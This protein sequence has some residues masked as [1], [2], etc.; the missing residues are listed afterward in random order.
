ME[1]NDDIRFLEK[2]FMN[3]ILGSIRDSWPVLFDTFVI[4]PSTEEEDTKL[5]FD[6]IICGIPISVR[7]R[8][9]KYINYRESNGSRTGLTIRSG[10]KCGRTTEIDKLR[11]G[12]GKLYFY[13]WMDQNEESIIGW[14]LIDIDKIRDKLD[15]FGKEHKNYDGT[16]FKSYGYSFL[17]NNNAIINK[18]NLNSISSY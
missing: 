12:S 10:S 11:N 4:L 5:S 7:I 15:R 8:E 18:G 1:N 6:V 2:K 9:Y 3:E 16:Y 13:S 14:L 17:E